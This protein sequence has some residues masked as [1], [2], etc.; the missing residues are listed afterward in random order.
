MRLSAGCA[1]DA[2]WR[3]V[4]ITAL[5][6]GAAAEEGMQC[7]RACLPVGKTLVVRFGW[8]E[9]QPRGKEGWRVEEL[10]AAEMKV[11]ALTLTL[12]LTYTCM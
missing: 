10:T 6:A 9:R 5:A 4:G 3:P 2:W 8:D 1:P 12:T 7:T 11:V